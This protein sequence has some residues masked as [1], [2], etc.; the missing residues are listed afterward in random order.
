MGGGGGNGSCRCA[1]D[2]YIWIFTVTLKG[3]VPLTKFDV[4]LEAAADVYFYENHVE[5][6]V[7]NVAVPSSTLSGLDIS[8]E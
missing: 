4:R 8:L 6:F 3:V 7:R 1:F 5:G 2:C